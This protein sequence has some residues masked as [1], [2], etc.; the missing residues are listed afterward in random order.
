MSLKAKYDVINEIKE[1]V[2]P[3]NHSE[4][5]SVLKTQSEA[6]FIEEKKK[7]DLKSQFLLKNH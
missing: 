3:L 4:I 2:V 6:V 1:N 5:K 7:Q